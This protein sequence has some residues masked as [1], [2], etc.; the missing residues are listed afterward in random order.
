M[1]AFTGIYVFGQ[2]NFKQTNGTVIASVEG[3][4]NDQK[5]IKINI[6]GF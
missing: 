1:S 5:N 6:K 2:P 4:S 3:F